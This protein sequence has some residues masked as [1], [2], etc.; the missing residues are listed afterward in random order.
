VAGS[1]RAA[2]VVVLAPEGALSL[3]ADQDRWSTFV[4]GFA[5]TL[6]VS[7]DWPAEG[8]RVVWESRPEGRGR[9]TEKVVEHG[10][11]RFATQ[12]FEDALV[13]RQTVTASEHADGTLVEVEL[14]YELSKY[15]PLRAVADAIFIRRALRDALARTLRRFAVEA[16]EEA[17]VR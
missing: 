7:P 16:E 17:G 6:E 14:E 5:R 1:A 9:V 4:E 11:G 13:G 3:W 8:S 12:V 2:E 15:G 10:P